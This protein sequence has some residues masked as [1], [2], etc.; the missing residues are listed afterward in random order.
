MAAQK[1]IYSQMPVNRFTILRA[2]SEFWVRFPMGKSLKKI[3]HRTS[4]IN[5]PGVLLHGFFY[6]PS[7]TQAL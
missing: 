5:E 4:C 7:I 1:L 3:A 2:V 6:S